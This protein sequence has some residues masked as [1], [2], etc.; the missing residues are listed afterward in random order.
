MIS[1]NKITEISK[2]ESVGWA[3]VEKDY[4]LTLVLESVASTPALHDN[5]VFKGGT[6]L[7]KVYFSDYRYS[8]DLDFTLKREFE[9]GEIRSLFGSAL[10]YLAREHNAD[11]RIRDFNSK[12]YF[13]DIK[14]QFVGLKGNKNTI[15]IDM[16]PSELIVDAQVELP[17]LNNYYQKSFDIGVYTLEEIVAEKLRSLM[18]RT[19]A[20]DYYDVWYLLTQG[21]RKLDKKKIGRIFAK[22]VEYKK[23]DFTGKEQLLDQ[24]KLTQ[25]EAYYQA[26]IGSQIKHLPPFG[27]I[28]EEL[29]DAIAQL[30]LD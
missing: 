27:K 12:K 21:K 10:D 11:M 26:Q 22:K 2:S 7:R 18:Q 1:S 13:T 3:V 14:V 6:A 29:K 24:E 20:R 19:R 4:F 17:V 25:A 23:I 28:A 8:E 15:A 16:S 9:S 5:L 30:D